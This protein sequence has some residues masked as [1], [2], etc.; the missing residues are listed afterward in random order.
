MTPQEIFNKAYTGVVAQGRA[1]RSGLCAYRLEPG[2][3]CGVG[4]LIS[5]ETAKLWDS[6]ANPNITNILNK[7]AKGTK[8]WMFKNQ[9]LLTDIQAAHDDC[10]GSED[11]VAEFKSSMHQVAKNYQLSVPS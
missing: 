8:P 6:M 10:N 9:Y 11:F 3:A 1:S 2:I 4:H 5:D 7:R